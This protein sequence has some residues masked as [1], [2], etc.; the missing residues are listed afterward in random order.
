MQKECQNCAHYREIPH[1]DLMEDRAWDGICCQE[2]DTADSRDEDDTCE[3]F[4][5]H[6]SYLTE[7]EWK[8]ALGC[9]SDMLT[10]FQKEHIGA[11]P[12]ILTL[13]DKL[14]IR[15]KNNAHGIEGFMR[16]K[17]KMYHDKEAKIVKAFE[18]IMDACQDATGF[19]YPDDT[20]AMREAL[21][22]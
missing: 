16:A 13:F 17:L 9:V 15:Q 14:A 1:N 10:A 18:I 12:D 3:D 5:D 4:I 20:D 2:D 22:P 11:P 6:R 21:Q 19:I 8:L 7:D